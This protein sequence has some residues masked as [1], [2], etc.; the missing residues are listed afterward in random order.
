M[1]RPSRSRTVRCAVCNSQFKTRHSQG[2]Y[3]STPCAR[4]GERKSWRNYGERNR[5]SRRAYQ[6]V[7]YQNNSGQIADRIK[8]YRQTNAG[9]TSQRKHDQRQR[10]KFPEKYQARQAVAIALRSGHLTKAPCAKC[11]AHDTHAHHH[12]YSKPL[13]IEW[14]CASCHR[15]EHKRSQTAG[16]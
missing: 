3:C 4:L 6:Q 7:H 5:A 8:A 12:D 15:V 9:K 14:L 1:R 11:G 2:K 13:D 10:Q 16:A